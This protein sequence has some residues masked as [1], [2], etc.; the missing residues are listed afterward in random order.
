MVDARQTLFVEEIG[1]SV[2]LVHMVILTEDVDTQS[3]R[4]RVNKT[5]VIIVCCEM[6]ITLKCIKTEKLQNPYVLS[7]YGVS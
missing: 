4:S 3:L 1:A 5:K 7:K 6:E 2:S